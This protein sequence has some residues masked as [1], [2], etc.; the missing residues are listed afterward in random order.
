MQDNAVPILGMYQDTRKVSQP[1]G[2]YV[3][4]L[5]AVNETNSGD[6]K[7]LSSERGT[8]YCYTLSTGHIQIGEI[9][10]D[11]NDKVIFS[12]N[13]L[14]TD[15]D[16]NSEISLITNQCTRTSLMK[17]DCLNFD[18]RSQVNGFYRLREGCKRTIYFR[19]K[20]NP[21][22]IIDID[23]LSNYQTDS[24]LGNVNSNWNCNLIKWFP[25]Y[26]VPQIDL[27][28]VFDSSGQIPVGVIQFTVT[29]MDEDL[30]PIG[31][32]TPT[33][34]IPVI[35]ESEG[36]SDRL[37]E[38]GYQEEIF[39]TSG[40][41]NKSILLDLSNID[42]QF[43]YIR[44]GV[45]ETYSGTT[46]VTRAI[47]K[48]PVEI[49]SSTM[50]ILYT[51]FNASTDIITTEAELTQARITYDRFEA[52][53]QQQNRAIAAGLQS[54]NIDLASIQKDIANN[55]QVKWVSRYR[56]AK[57]GSNTSK[58]PEH[59]FYELSMPRDEVIPLAFVP[60]FKD[61]SEGPAFHIPGRLKNTTH[62][63]TP[64]NASAQTLIDTI[65]QL[66]RHRRPPIASNL[67][68]V[69]S[70]TGG[71]NGDQGWD[72]ANYD[73]TLNDNYK[74]DMAHIESNQ[75]NTSGYVE[76]WQ[77]YNTAFSDESNSTQSST[78]LLNN[79]ND[80]D[81]VEKGQMGYHESSKRYP[82]TQTCDGE[83]IYPRELDSSGVETGNMAF[84][85]H[86]RIPDSAIAPHM[87]L[88]D[89]DNTRY[90]KEGTS[91]HIGLYISNVNIPTA[92]QAEIQGWKIVRA[93][94]QEQDRTVIDRGIVFH[95][96]IATNTDLT[97]KIQYQTA[98]FNKHRF[99][100]Q[101]Y[102][103]GATFIG[104]EDTCNEYYPKIYG[105]NYTDSGSEEMFKADASTY[106][107]AAFG[108]PLPDSAN[109]VSFHG[110]KSKFQSKFLSGDYIKFDLD[111]LGFVRWF[112]SNDGTHDDKDGEGQGNN[113]LPPALYGT[114]AIV[115]QNR[116]A[117]AWCTY[118]NYQVPNRKPK[119]GT[120]LFHDYGTPY[121]NRKIENQ[122]F[123]DSDTVSIQGNLDTTFLNNTQQETYA[124]ECTDS[125]PLNA[126]D[127]EW[128]K[129]Y[130]PFNQNWILPDDSFEELGRSFTGQSVA[131]YVSIKRNLTQQFSDLPSI[132]YIDLDNQIQP[133]A[134]TTATIYG[135]DTHISLFESRKTDQYFTCGADKGTDG[136][137]GWYGYSFL[138][139]STINTGLR[140]GG[141]LFS[142]YD[143]TSAKNDCEFGQA[144]RYPAK[145]YYGDNGYIPWNEDQ[146]YKYG[147]IFDRNLSSDY[148]SLAYC[149]KNFYRYNQDFS[150]PNN[151][152]YYIPL[153]QSF[154]WCTTCQYKHPHQYIYSESSFQE[155][156]TDHY[157]VF[158]PLNYKLL[159]GHTGD[160]N[161]LFI[162][163]DNLFIHTKQ[164]LWFQATN[165]QTM[166]TNE[167]NLYIGTGEFFSIPAKELISKPSGYAGCQHKWSIVPTEYGV[168]WIDA[169]AGDVILFNESP[170]PIS[171]IGMTSFFKNNSKLLLQE[172]IT[173]LDP[174][175]Y[176]EEEGNTD[177]SANPNGCGYMAVFDNRNARYILSK[178]DYKL[179]D[180]STYV[181]ALVLA[182]QI[183]G[184]TATTGSITFVPTTQK[185]QLY[186]GSTYTEIFPT[187]LTY[188]D[189]YSWTVSFSVR[190]KSWTSFH[191]YIPSFMYF[192][193]DTFYSTNSNQT[194]WSHD[195]QNVQSYYE[196]T[197]PLI[198][199]SIINSNPAITKRLQN[200]SYLSTVEEY[201][202]TNKSYLDIEDQTFTK[203]LVYTDT[204]TTGELTITPKINPY[205]SLTYS[206][207]LCTAD[208][209]GHNR[210]WKINRLRDMVNL[211]SSSLFTKDQTNTLFQA[212]FPIDHVVNTS[213]INTSK[214]QYELAYLKDKY[215]GIRFFYTPTSTL[216]KISLDLL[217]LNINQDLR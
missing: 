78:D 130:A 156:T 193:R 187:D 65:S 204:Q 54:K 91:S 101:W 12:V 127:M 109:S 64:I 104:D 206:N 99:A 137:A 186:N 7:S 162:K 212:E 15:L 98:G 92:L 180:E 100:R 75:L 169:N 182:L 39:P 46:Q 124:I 214:S 93:D 119:H 183:T 79:T 128:G 88:R 121:Y 38:G 155:E 58:T 5:N 8:D 18:L 190:D 40:Y 66:A 177:N 194:I 70:D 117:K 122:H 43:K 167:G 140:H 165:P 83:Y 149:H 50:S 159:P 35:M 77:V 59:Y 152:K 174:Q 11:G 151:S 25:D 28:Q 148:L 211:R 138:V 144:E 172:Q 42:T 207:I 52:I 36:T 105:L 17:S 133:T 131:H 48:P 198:I 24:S 68:G 163:N 203:I 110:P 153:E 20:D 143:G 184:G 199:D 205:D 89:P 107:Q 168:F 126:F 9:P 49:S 13:Q 196:S 202:T 1:P 85:R 213:V 4:A 69:G 72:S 32:I 145:Y 197:K 118:K 161:S 34:P 80:S 45:L 112:T 116:K 111:L 129:H 22:R 96:V 71:I 176:P 87:G 3:Y 44:L 37:K 56:N 154:D 2:S 94:L 132:R 135:G 67:A 175:I 106:D 51:G 73:P 142:G 173:R 217:S 47:L 74:A 86:H 170:D 210:S 76:R 171:N 134:N 201:D 195:S 31:Y 53:T 181:N 123:I 90:M 81:W 26:T 200:L 84:I 192:D 14:S 160:I 185:W 108:Y 62:D 55:I 102:P 188:F 125:I 164:S 136:A 33:N 158:R 120:G 139:E 30:N 95:N 16:G 41:T 189:N 150:K 166:L 60:I 61:G 6:K 21:P 114:D 208:R 19:D 23:T 216:R 27:N 57:E 113:T 179:R 29:Y 215:F 191:S 115:D 147:T 63:G 97:K 146:R 157:R 103:D 82:S 141:N 10:L 209:A 178:K